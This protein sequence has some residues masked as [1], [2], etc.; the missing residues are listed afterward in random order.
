LKKSVR[1][2]EEHIMVIKEGPLMV[3]NRLTNEVWM[4]TPTQPKLFYTTE[5]AAH[6]IH[7]H[8][9]ARHLDDW[10]IVPYL[11]PQS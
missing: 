9:D 10:E 11:G 7:L 4:D 5:A 2:A 8:K 6:E 3:R 1:K